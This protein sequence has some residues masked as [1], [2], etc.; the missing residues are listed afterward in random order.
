[1]A[2]LGYGVRREGKQAMAA[3]G[4]TSVLPVALGSVANLPHLLLLRMAPEQALRKKI[5]RAQCGAP[6]PEKPAGF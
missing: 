3:E 4:S 5:I 6:G 2:V 1:M